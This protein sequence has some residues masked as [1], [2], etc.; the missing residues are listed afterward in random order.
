DLSNAGVQLPERTLYAFHTALKAQDSS[1][2]TV[3]AGISGTGKSLLPRMYAR[4]I[5]M[6]FLNLPIQPRW[7]SPQDLFGFYNYIEHK[8]K[9]TD[10]ARAMIQFNLYRGA[11]WPTTDAPDL[12]DQMLLVLLDEMNLARIEY[13]FSELLSRLEIRRDIDP[14]N[15][16]ERAQV[17]VALEIGHGHQGRG[18]VRI[19]PGGNVLFAGTMNEDEST[20]ALSEKVLDRASVLRFG[21]PTRTLTT[22]PELADFAEGE[23]L[24]AKTWEVWK[25]SRNE[26]A[27]TT[28]AEV[29]QQ[30]NDLMDRVG[31]PFGHRTSHGIANYV[32]MYPNRTAEGTSFAIADQI[33]Q[34]ILPNL[35]GLDL[36]A[37]RQHFEDLMRIVDSLDDNA[38]L[39]ELRKR[40]GD[41]NGPFM[42]RGLDRS[43]DLM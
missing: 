21:R 22:P 16:E 5:G 10:L 39:N 23:A 25:G 19:F 4:A 12:S 24:S 17:E 14:D 36:E 43:E 2:L 26:T 20:Q 18:D 40:V 30:L 31:S 13:Y 28:T 29:I 8:Y 42:W 6:Y 3:L 32:A 1:P 9:A 41:G 7:D 27:I 35:R 37:D 11:S 33:E 34:K 38:L 15:Q